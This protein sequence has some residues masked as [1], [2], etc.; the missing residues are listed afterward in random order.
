MTGTTR[1]THYHVLLDEVG[2]SPD[3]LQEI[4][5]SLSYMYQR[6]TTA[7]SIA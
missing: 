1:P 7:I 5:H 2:F 6:S 3:N 4:M